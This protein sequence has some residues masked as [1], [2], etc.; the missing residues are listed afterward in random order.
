MLKK[1][2]YIVTFFLLLAFSLGMAR[3]P[4]KAMPRQTKAIFLQVVVEDILGEME[5]AY[6]FKDRD[7]FFSFL[8]TGF[9]DLP[10]FESILGSY[11]S[12]ISKPAIHFFIDMVIADKNGINVKARWQRRALTSSGV[13][14]KAQGKSQLI[15]KRYPE[16]LK[17]K[18]ILQENPFF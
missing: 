10:R 14:I 2:F 8:D 4:K 3:A 9:D 17:L 16:G 5:Y 1:P 6:A 12:S 18:R 11:F 13:L 15:F 7:A